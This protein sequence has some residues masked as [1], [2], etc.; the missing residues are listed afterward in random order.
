MIELEIKNLK[1][2]K[3]FLVKIPF[4]KGVYAITGENGVGK[5][6]IF[7]VLAQLIS[8]TSLNR[9]FRKDGNINSQI[10]YRFNGKENIWIKQNT[11]WKLSNV[12]EEINL[13]GLFEGSL[14][15]GSRFSDVNKLILNKDA[16]PDENQLINA[17]DFII[18]NLGMILRND[19]LFYKDLKRIK[20][21]KL[22]KEL[23]RFEGQPYF[24]QTDERLISQFFMS[25][26]ELLL[27][28]LLDFINQK[29]RNERRLENKSLVLIDEIE[30][31]LH[32]SAQQRLLKFLIDIA[33]N[34][35]LCIYI[36]THS[37][38]IINDIKS[39]KIYHIERE[40]SGNLK[41]INPCYPAY[42]TRS[43][44]TNDGFDFVF[45]V[46]DELIE[47]IVEAIMRKHSLKSSKLVKILP[48][49]NWAQVLQMHNEMEFSN[50]C[51]GRCKIISILD[52]DIKEEC[53]KLDKKKP[54]YS[55]LLKNFLPID[56]VEKFLNNNL[57]NT[58]N[59][60]F[61]QKLEATY[62]HSKSLNSILDKYS[63]ENTQDNK[64]KKLF[65]YLIDSAK[66]TGIVEENFKVQIC[67]FIYE[68]ESNNFL[69]LEK[70]II[71]TLKT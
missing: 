60:E 22:A 58:P 20:T 17:K 59:G 27:L 11:K 37:I 45:L 28:G 38:Q 66:E 46:E 8:K 7:S 1:N 44:Y 16:S 19:K 65:T 57:I 21:K 2:I 68:H 64:G 41:I 49:G 56:S 32:P 36:A 61:I 39:S 31:A 63:R 54:E 50:L 24:L 26:G 52:G 15:L 14:M 30:L 18:N 62:F 53:Q 48:C 12:A 51:G 4:E 25:S 5:S 71:D 29:I 35:N 43:L 69:S 70:F 47:Y 3:Q 9:L 42:A 55:R 34:Y 40:R 67:N 13:D 10:I 33:D 23:Y 6:T